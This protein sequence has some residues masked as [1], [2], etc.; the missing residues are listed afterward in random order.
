[1]FK[2]HMVLG[3]GWEYFCCR[4]KIV[5]GDLVVFKLSGLGL[6]VQIFNAN[7]SNICKVQCSK[8]NCIG[9]I[10][11]DMQFVCLKYEPK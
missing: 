8:H 10:K 6:K 5:P 1:M 2:G 3:R 9:D 4:H 7:T 11:H